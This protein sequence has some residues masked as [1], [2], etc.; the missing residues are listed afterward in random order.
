MQQ[1]QNSTGRILFR[2]L[3][4][5]ALIY[6]GLLLLLVICQ[7]KIIYYP[8][9]SSEQILRARAETAGLAPCKDA[10][11][12]VIGWRD[13]TQ[14]GPAVPANRLVVFHGNAGFAL[15]RSYFLEGFRSV[16][17]GRIWEVYLFEYPGYGARAGSPS[18]KAFVEAARQALRELKGA[19]PRPVFLLG[20]SIGAGV[21][22]ALAGQLPDQ[23]AG[24]I[25]ITPF[26]TLADVAASHYPFFPVRALLRDRYNNPAALANYRGPA[27]FLLAGRDE[28]IPAPLGRELYDHYAGPKQLWVQEEATHNTLDYHPGSGWW[29]EVTAFLLRENRLPQ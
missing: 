28:I 29:E 22:C 8:S 23:V 16:S 24:V 17:S 3:R 25:L 9:K 19:D 21:A 10:E 7:R 4:T 2:I 5:V 1:K 15:H 11:G 6:V 14:S 27:A 20:E 26:T 12:R 18:E 13:R